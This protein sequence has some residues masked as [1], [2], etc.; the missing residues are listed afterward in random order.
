VPS[1]FVVS[2][3]DDTINVDTPEGLFDLLES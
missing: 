1:N 2:I 3:V